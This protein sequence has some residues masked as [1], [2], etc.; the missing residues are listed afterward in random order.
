MAVLEVRSGAPPA[1]LSE[2]LLE[3]GVPA[4]LRLGRGLVIRVRQ[5]SKQGLALG[6]GP[7]TRIRVLRGRQ[8]RGVRVHGGTTT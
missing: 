3:L 7:P 1:Y 6:P 2:R 8:L 4:E 5:T